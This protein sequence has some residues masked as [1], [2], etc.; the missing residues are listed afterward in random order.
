SGVYKIKELADT[1][2][3]VANDKYGQ[4]VKIQRL[5]NPRVEAD[6]HPFETISRKLPN[7]FGFERKVSLR[8][9]IDRMLELLTRDE[10]QERI[11]QVKDVIM[12]ET[13]WSGEKE[14]PDVIE[15]Y[16]PGEKD[17]GIYEPKLDTGRSESEESEE[18][19]EAGEE[20]EEEEAERV[21][22]KIEE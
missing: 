4:D 5:E 1:V 18:E 7:E 6:K 14:R 19:E 8:K 3:E 16:S 12:P 2:G 15:V 22:P 10:I 11:E 9:E 21:A 13:Q 20:V 17:W